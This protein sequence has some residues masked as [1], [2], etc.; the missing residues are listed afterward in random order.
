MTKWVIAFLLAIVG[1]VDTASAQD[2]WARINT[3]TARVGT[4]QVLVDASGWGQLCKGIRIAV[5]GAS[6]AIERISIVYATGRVHAENVSPPV[7][8]APG[9]QSRVF[10]PTNDAQ[11][12]RLITIRFSRL[13]RSARPATIEV[14]G[15]QPPAPTVAP[16]IARRPELRMERP[17]APGG[18]ATP[19]ARPRIQ[20]QP[21]EMV[22]ATRPTA[23]S[24]PPPAPQP[25]MQTQSRESVDA[26]RSGDTPRARSLQVPAP[27]ARAP[28][29]A[30]PPVATAPPEPPAPPSA[31]KRSAPAKAKSRQL[32]SEADPSKPYNEIDVFFGTDRK[33]EADRSKFGR[34]VAAFG[35]GRSNNLTL[36]KAVVTVPKEGREK[37][38]IPRPEWDL[39]IARFSLRDEDLSRDFTVFAVDVMNRDTFVREA[40]AKL[41]SSSRFQGQA[42][43]F[44]HGYFV[45]FDDALFRAAQIAHDLEFDGVPFVYSWPSVAGLTGYVLDRGRARDARD[46]LRDFV[47]IIAK[48]SGATEVH[49]IAHSMGAD[50]LLEVLRDIQRSEPQ[51]ARGDRPRFGEI[52][53]AAPDVTRESFELIAAQITG[54]RRGMTLYASSNDRALAAS[55]WTRLGESPAG[56]VPSGGPVVVPG[57]A[58]TIDISSLDTS[59]FAV[60]H[61]TFADREALLGDIRRLISSGLRP[62]STR[63]PEFE[64]IQSTGGAYWRYKK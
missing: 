52:I 7:R 39:L 49:L 9:A 62:P 41:A 12:I 35:T 64:L 8:V 32:T 11:Q 45:T 29:A 24:A 2:R 33:Q 23:R 48:E 63:G 13:D 15:L 30:P 34:A 20:S 38:S 57:A 31:A 18:G 53:L 6:I 55:R 44:V 40:R 43:V 25:R 54:L 17:P 19:P 1:I 16:P 50:P 26:S 3:V 14:W 5:S 47:D 10:A 37:G 58:D 61:S 59:F 21:R 46:H 56:Y 28:E 60:N 42:F 22:E 51:V 36:G 4:Q 27:S